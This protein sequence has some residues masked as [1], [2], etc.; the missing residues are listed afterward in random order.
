MYLA[1]K[2]KLAVNYFT[3]TLNYF[4]ITLNFGSGASVVYKCDV[5]TFSQLL[6][7][8]LKL[9]IHI[10]KKHPE[11]SP[12]TSRTYSVGSMWDI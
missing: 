9:I 3:I 1:L 12:L 4:A 10:F 5:Q 6:Y 2:Q 7:W 11:V 8:A